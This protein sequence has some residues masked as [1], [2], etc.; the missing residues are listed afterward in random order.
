LA[1]A[2]E[3]RVAATAAAN[4][5]SKPKLT[6]LHLRSYHSYSSQLSTTEDCPNRDSIYNSAALEKTARAAELS[7]IKRALTKD[8][9]VIADDSN[10]IKGFRYQLW[11]EAKAAGTRCCTVHCAAREDE[12]VKWNR[13]RLRQWAEFMGEDAPEEEDAATT[14]DH[15]ET[16]A[17]GES[18]L[19]ESHTALYGDRVPDVSSRS[20]SSS[21]GAD[22]GEE[23]VARPSTFIEESLKSFSLAHQSPAPTNGNSPPETM[24]INSIPS[25]A[26][27]TIDFPPPTSPPYSSKTLQSLL[28][29]YEPP[30]PFS[31]WDT[32]LFTVP[33]SD[34]LPPVS[35]IWDALLPPKVAKTARKG[36]APDPKE[37]V[38]P[39]AATALPQATGADAL[40]ILERVTAQV[41]AQIMTQIKEHLEWLDQGGGVEVRFADTVGML[42][43]PIGTVV[44][45]PMLQRLRRRFTQIQRGGIAHGRGHVKGEK[46]VGEAFLR[47]LNAEMGN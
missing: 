46:A 11:C 43:V 27:T 44:N 6:V 35:A 42:S 40:Q 29:R 3:E 19:P 16:K 9:I 8:A 10:Y 33:T 30:S 17:S 15:L 28:M 24:E 39:H 20:R 4:T 18:R 38:K 31:K 1:S 26:A 14:N 25:T 34:P 21:T 12:V 13:V 37:D 23:I 7:A 22:D 5:S 41:V 32:P 47:F 2:L 36:G 45:L